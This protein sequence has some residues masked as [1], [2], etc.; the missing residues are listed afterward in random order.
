MYA[1]VVKIQLAHPEKFKMLFPMLGP[2]HTTK[3]GL[4]CIGKFIR[5]SGFEDA[6]IETGMYGPKT[7]EAVLGG[8][9]Y[10]R[11]MF[12]LMALAETITTL[13]LDAFWLTQDPEKHTD[14]LPKLDRLRNILTDK[15]K[16]SAQYLSDFVNNQNIQNLIAEIEK[17]TNT[18]C[19]NSEQCEFLEEFIRQVS[20]VKCFVAAD[21]DGDFLLH[22]KKIGE[23]C[24][25]F[26][27]AGSFNYVR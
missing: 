22:V 17:F 11:S 9:H 16:S 27:G 23:L 5:G 8:K 10:Y 3:I 25:M 14:I 12:G 1:E 26:L 15:D 19:E 2:F 18:C 7:C 13:K 20:I 21:R 24:P 6:F 4:K